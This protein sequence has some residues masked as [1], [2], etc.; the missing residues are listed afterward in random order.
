[1][2]KIPNPYKKTE[3]NK[4]N[5]ILKL[6]LFPFRFTW[7]AWTGLFDREKGFGGALLWLIWVFIVFGI[8]MF[9]EEGVL[10]TQSISEKRNNSNEKNI[11]YRKIEYRKNEYV[12]PLNKP[13]DT[14]ANIFNEKQY[15]KK[16]LIK[17]IEEYGPLS[18]RK[19]NRNWY[20]YRFDDAL[21][22]TGSRFKLFRIPIDSIYNINYTWKERYQKFIETDNQYQISYRNHLK[23]TYSAKGINYD[24][25]KKKY[26]SYNLTNKFD[27]VDFG[28]ENPINSD[29]VKQINGSALAYNTSQNNVKNIKIKIG[30]YS[31]MFDGK[32]IT[33]DIYTI[34]D[35]IESGEMKI[36]NIS[37][38]LKNA[39]SS[40]ARN[41]VDLKILDYMKY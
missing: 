11:E 29:F 32:L 23:K 2:S 14:L 39:F 16:S 25:E 40:D 36:L 4:E 22:Y 38:K 30:I 6:F 15:S 37:Y 28:Y 8:G 27:I 12:H 7:L 41:A 17:I 13:Y 20:L 35:S 18:F 19:E 1:M 9:L 21:F 26:E 31:D 5:F 33:E 3:K 34:K 24:F 10:P